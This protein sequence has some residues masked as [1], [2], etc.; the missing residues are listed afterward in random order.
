MVKKTPPNTPPLA[1]V[2]SIAS[3]Q[4]VA[5]SA[6]TTDWLNDLGL[7]DIRE[8]LLL[9]RLL[10]PNGNLSED[11][12]GQK[13]AILMQA[14]REEN[15][16]LLAEA[17]S[18]LHDGAYTE[19]V[20][21]LSGGE[22]DGFE[23]GFEDLPAG[24]AHF[25]EFELRLVD[26]PIFTARRFRLRAVETANLLHLH[27]AIQAVAG[28]RDSHLADFLDPD[29]GDVVGE[30]HPDPDNA[31][32]G[33]TFRKVTIE[34][35]FSA[36]DMLI[37]R[38]DYGDGWKVATY[39]LGTFPRI[40][41]ENAALIEAVGPYPPDDCGGTR[42]FAL[43]LDLVKKRNTDARMSRDD[44]EFLEWLGDWKPVVDVDAITDALVPV[45]RLL[46]PKAPKK[47]TKKASKKASKKAPTKKTR[48]KSTAKPTKP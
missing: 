2:I 35:A 8:M 19:L 22:D 24:T 40:P 45:G 38:Y 27:L 13:A 9:F 26:A 30:L 18:H 6:S 1:K 47:P 37:Y 43:A 28:W 32:A 12:T 16:D 42:R 23:D 10:N 48:T 29:N 41:A 21:Y 14:L 20:R 39:Y 33:P 4:V 34:A 31:E 46:T 17:T 5:P 25:Y 3:G 15:G 11:A 44:R 7:D 36:R